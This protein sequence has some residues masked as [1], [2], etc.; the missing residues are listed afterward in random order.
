MKWIFAAVFFG[1]PTA[2]YCIVFSI[3]WDDHAAAVKFV[4]S[5]S[6]R[7]GFTTL[8]RPLFLSIG[9]W[10]SGLACLGSICALSHGDRVQNE[11]T[12]G[13][14]EFGADGWVCPH[15]HE[16]NLGNFDECGSVSVTVRV[17]NPAD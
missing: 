17:S 16:S 1:N 6:G 8:D 2:M 11:E 3:G 10:I 7:G 15:C 12:G 4:A 5:Q 14:D 9:A 13:T